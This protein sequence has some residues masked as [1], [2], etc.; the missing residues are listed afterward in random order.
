MINV[1]L[2]GFG[3]SGSTFHAPLISTTAGL[4]LTHILS[5]QKEKI[6]SIYPDVTVVEDLNDLLQQSDIDLIINTL[7]NSEHYTITLQCLLAGKH[8]VV[9]KPFV[10]NS[11]QGEELIGLAKT[12]NLMLSVY[13]NRRWDNGFLTL[14]QQLPKLGNVFHYESYFDRFR[15]QVN[16]AKWRE[17]DISG[18]GIIYDLGSHLIDQ[19]LCLFGMP[20]AIS[21]DLAKQRIGSQAVDYFQVTLIYAKHRAIL[22]SSSVIANPR[23][24]LAIYGDLGSYVK[25]GLDPQENMLKAGV[26]PNDCTY[27]IEEGECS[28]VLSLVSTDGIQATTIASEL[29]AYPEYYS[30][31]KSC[32]SDGGVTPVSAESAL[33]V[34]RLIELAIK[35]SASGRV[36]K[37]L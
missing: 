6:L 26:L 19:A 5:R 21:A 13:H 8:V 32:L 35:S 16:L 18:S 17:Q 4:K 27:G 3:L 22:G 15:P 37:L 31:I 29:G 30:Q 34:I 36:I 9:E 2:L 24:A 14:K 7:P 28:G 1:A 11:L 12:K 25:N 33:Q 10:I 20:L 23:P